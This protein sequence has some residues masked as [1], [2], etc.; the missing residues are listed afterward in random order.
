M[1]AIARLRKLPISARKVSLLATLI[2]GKNVVTALAVLQSMPQQAAVQLRKLLLSA[3]SNWQNNNYVS[4]ED[5][6]VVIKKITVDGAGMLKRIMPSSRGMAHRIRKRF[7]HVTIVVDSTDS[8]C[9]PV[10]NASVEQ[11]TK[12]TNVEAKDQNTIDESL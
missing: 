1:E 8:V 3:V 5:T 6:Q 12:N 2:R 7:S 4:F 9:A 10:T 11:H